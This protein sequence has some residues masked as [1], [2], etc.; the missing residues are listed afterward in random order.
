MSNPIWNEEKISDPPAVALLHEFGY[1]EAPAKALEFER[2]MLKV[3]ILT[4]R[5]STALQCLN[6]W[7]S[8]TRFAKVIKQIVHVLAVN[9]TETNE[10]LCNHLT[11]GLSIEQDLN[12]GRKGQPVQFFDFENP[13]NNELDYG[14]A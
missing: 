5:L 8:P 3:A 13:S 10:T 6:P 12:A 11:Y 9:L 1:T 2:F 4:P 7:L 14:R